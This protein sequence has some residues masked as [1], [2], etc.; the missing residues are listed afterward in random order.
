MGLSLNR[1]T[2]F[3]TPVNINKEAGK[4]RMVFHG[5][6]LVDYRIIKIEDCAPSISEMP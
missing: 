3:Q 4:V 6:T 5:K 1:Y 2:T